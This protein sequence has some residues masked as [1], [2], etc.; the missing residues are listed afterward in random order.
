VAYLVSDGGLRG[1]FAACLTVVA[2]R[3]VTSHELAGGA[4]LRRTRWWGHPIGVAGG[5]HSG[6]LGGGGGGHRRLH[7]A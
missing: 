4:V 1:L 3:I 7:P 2:V 5:M 6:L